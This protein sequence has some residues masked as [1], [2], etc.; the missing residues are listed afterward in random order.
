[1]CNFFFFFFEKDTEIFIDNVQLF[2]V[3]PKIASNEN[4]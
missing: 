4:L 1:M 3:S 2:C